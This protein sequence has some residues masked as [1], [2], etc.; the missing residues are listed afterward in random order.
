M[1]HARVNSVAVGIQRERKRGRRR[2]SKKEK[3][4][5][6]VIIIIAGNRKGIG[7][8]RRTSRRKEERKVEGKS[9]ASRAC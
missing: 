7:C 8:A 4:R 1:T 3:G 2:V 6:V 5:I 9:L